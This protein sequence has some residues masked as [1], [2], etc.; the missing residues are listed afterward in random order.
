MASVGLDVVVSPVSQ[1]AIV[2][3][4]SAATAVLQYARHRIATSELAQDI[5]RSNRNEVVGGMPSKG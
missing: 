2:A 4:S 1:V 5:A 3:F